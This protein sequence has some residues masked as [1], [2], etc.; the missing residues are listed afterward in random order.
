V[1]SLR[2][3]SLIAVF[4]G[5]GKPFGGYFAGLAHVSA[6]QVKGIL[7]SQRSRSL[8]PID[9]WTLAKLHRTRGR[10]SGFSRT[11]AFEHHLREA[12]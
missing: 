9:P 6:G 4:L 1:L 8:L 5:Q 10:L 2:N 12:H 7:V 11:E 3:R